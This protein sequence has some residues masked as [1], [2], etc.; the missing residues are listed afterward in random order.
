MTMGADPIAIATAM[1]AAERNRPLKAFS[2]RKTA[3][4]HGTGGRLVG[5][6]Q[7]GMKVAILEDTT[8]TGGAAAEAADAAGAEGLEVIQAIAL[9]DRSGG[10]AREVFR[11]L[12][13]PYVALVTPHDLGVTS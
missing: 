1:V 7:S 9:V 8:T 4:E 3:K 6:V 11:G 12:D 10:A 13:V 5:P 2:I